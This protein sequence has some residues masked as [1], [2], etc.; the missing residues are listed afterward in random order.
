MTTKS[1]VPTTVTAMS[2]G[3]LSGA[4]AYSSGI[5]ITHSGSG[6]T[7]PPVCGGMHTIAFSTASGISA[8][9]HGPMVV[10]PVNELLRTADH[11]DE[12]MREMLDG[13][14]DKA[15]IKSLP[16]EIFANWLAGRAEGLENGTLGSHT[17]DA[18]ATAKAFK[19]P[20]EIS[21]K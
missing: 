3:A 17:K 20:L 18:V 12:F 10:P 7:G 21:S 19:K 13:G 15:V 9:S 11:M 4:V 5:S 2:G 14:V 8:V 1:I 16:M 6:Y